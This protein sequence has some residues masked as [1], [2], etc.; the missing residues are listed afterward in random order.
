MRKSLRRLYRT[1]LYLIRYM[2]LLALFLG[3][4]AAI[5][6][7]APDVVR[8]RPEFPFVLAG[9]V[10]SSLAAPA[11]LL[12]RRKRALPF[13]RY[14]TRPAA[15]NGHDFEH[16]VARS[17][18]RQGWKVVVTSRSGDQ[19]IDVIATRHGRRVGIQCKHYSGSVG[20][21]AVQEAYSGK[22]YHRTHVA[23]VITTGRYT[24]SAH[25]LSKRT[26]VHLLHVRDI[27]RMHRIIWM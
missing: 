21:K 20:N 17:L 9:L 23:A 25:E 15:R 1:L 26:G 6:A 14:K 3:S 7:F 4:C 18:R 27:P 5:S 11:L 8:R 2:L 24:A 22:A 12:R 16:L 10:L 13:R 19:G